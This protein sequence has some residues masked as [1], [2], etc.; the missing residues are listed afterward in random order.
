[1]RQRV[2]IEPEGVSAVD[3]GGLAACYPRGMRD[4]VVI[5]GVTR[6]LGGR[7]EVDVAI[8]FGSRARGEHRPD[9]DVDVAVLGDVDRLA[10]AAELSRA[11]GHEVEVVDLDAAGYP[12]LTAIVRENGVVTKP[13]A[14]A[15]AKAAGLRN[16]VARGFPGVDIE[17]V[18]AA[19]PRGV[20]DLDAFASEVG[21]RLQG[22]IA[23]P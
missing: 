20:R 17:M 5:D 13:T 1:V 8:L 14:E 2:H 6:A 16:V 3:A 21:A 15:M 11:K 23:A 22:R 12:L 4:T 7:R 10:L 18:F 19:A 9:S